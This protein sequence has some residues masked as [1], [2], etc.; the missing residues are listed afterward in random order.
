[1]DTH[2][3]KKK[4][5]KQN[6]T[7]FQTLDFFIAENKFD[8]TKI[9]SPPLPY[10]VGVR[11]DYPWPCTRTPTSSPPSPRKT[12]PGSPNVGGAIETATPLL[13]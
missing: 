10:H 6:K 13:E 5:K 7:N 12:L 9:S 1:M 11:T 3:E 2:Q 8:L 4:Q